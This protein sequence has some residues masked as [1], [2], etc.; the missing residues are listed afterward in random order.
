MFGFFKQQERN[1]KL[2]V[3]KKIVCNC[4]QMLFT[5]LSDAKQPLESQQIICLRTIN[6]D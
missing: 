5:K 6:K 1:E 4:S 2:R 3:C